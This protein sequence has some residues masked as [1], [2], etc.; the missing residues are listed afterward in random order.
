MAR[1]IYSTIG[2]V[3]GYTVDANGSFAW[4]AP[5]A[6]VHAFLNDLE[7]PIG[8]Y[9]Y[10]RGMYQTMAVW[11]TLDQEPDQSAESLDYARIWRGADKVVY[12]S[13]LAEVT[14][15]KTRLERAFDPAA[16]RALKS[17]ADRDI[18]VGGPTLAAAAI[19]AGLV[20]EYQLFLVP[21]L[22]GGGTRALPDGVYTAI[23][24]VEQ[25]RFADG[26]MFLRYT[27]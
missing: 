27:V 19:R 20:D 22:V 24:L 11:Q 2:S 16:V 17:A 12:S 4:A 3:D 8:T 13:T 15:P 1:L 25:R 9:L 10:G 7:R 5:A 26:T 14:T 6:D 21:H 18:T 23:T